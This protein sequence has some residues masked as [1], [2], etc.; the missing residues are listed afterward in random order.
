MIKYISFY[1]E[2]RKGL[3]ELHP[4]G[5]NYIFWN[6]MG[7][8]ESSAQGGL[9]IAIR[10]A[11]QWMTLNYQMIITSQKK[12]SHGHKVAAIVNG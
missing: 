2:K 1:Y 5:F 9:L 12:R 10:K 6:G 7:F 3:I 11:L 4:D 8:S